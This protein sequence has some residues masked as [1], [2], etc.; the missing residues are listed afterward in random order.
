MAERERILARRDSAERE[1][2]P[3][4]GRLWIGPAGREDERPD[5]RRRAIAI[6]DDASEL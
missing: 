2:A 5:Q 4:V 6:E 3:G 1:A